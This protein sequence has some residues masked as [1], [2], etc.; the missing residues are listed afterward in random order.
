MDMYRRQV[1][2]TMRT[3]IYLTLPLSAFMAVAAPQIVAGLYQ[4][5]KFTAQDA[6]NVAICL[7]WFCV[8]IMAW[9]LHPIVTRAFYAMHNSL[10]PTIIGTIITA[11]FVGS[12]YAL[13]PTS[14]GMLA[15]PI[16]SSM[17]AILLAITM[18]IF[19]RSKIGGLDLSGIFTT[20]WKSAIGTVVMAGITWLVLLTPVGHLTASHSG[21]QRIL[22]LLLI[23]LLAA[24]GALVYLGVTKWM[25]MPECSYLDRVIARIS[26]KKPVAQIDE[27]PIAKS[28]DEQNPP[29]EP[30]G[31]GSIDPMEGA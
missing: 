21:G 11:F 28:D 17:S 22:G 4:H 30:P 15:L 23:M 8:G 10:I 26:G 5:G 24:P 27:S 1:A 31:G 29:Y 25:K 14:L 19:L 18:I 6:A 16:A 20:F 12:V 13:K 3:V 9:C 2:S 7:Q